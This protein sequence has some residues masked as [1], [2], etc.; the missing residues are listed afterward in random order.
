FEAVHG[1]H[2][3]LEDWVEELPRFLGI[4]V[5]QQFHGSLQVG[6]Q[7]SDLLAFAFQG[8]PGSENLFSQVLRRMG[9]RGSKG[10][11]GFRGWCRRNQALAALWTEFCRQCGFKAT[12]RTAHALPALL[13]ELGDSAIL[14]LALRTLHTASSLF[15]CLG[16][17]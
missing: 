8:I 15:A 11:P 5:G 14:V 1:C 2:Q 9:L 7:H 10:D 16:Y 12:G 3:A 4:T 17:L 13:A 6:E